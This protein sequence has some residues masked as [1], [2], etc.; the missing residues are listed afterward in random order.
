M[1]FPYIDPVIVQIGP[2]ALRWYGLTYVAGLVALWLLGNYRAQFAHNN[3]TKEQVSDFITY[4]FL[5]IFLGGRF[6][7]V[8]FYNFDRFL[9]NPLYLFKV[10]E[11]GMSF[12]GGL[13]GVCIAFA[14]FARHTQKRYFEVA[15][16]LAP[17][18]PLGLG[19]GRI[20]NFINGE[21]WGREV[22]DQSLPWAMRFACNAEKA[23][24]FTACDP[25]ALLRHPSQLYQALLEGLVLFVI[26]FLFSRKPRPLMSVSGMFLFFYGLFRFIVEFFREPDAHLGLFFG[27]ALS[28]GQIL[29]LPMIIGGGVLVFL[30]Y[31]RNEM[32][33]GEITT[34]QNKAKNDNKLRTARS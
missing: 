10:W 17:M 11:G 21:L 34:K 22:V 29:S 9:D 31:R 18:V 12:H 26:L 1:D 32:P 13:I 28:M 33:R 5:G 14:L 20:G 8:L 19:F 25:A 7:Y 16:F 3:W 23:P 4:A 24:W 15:D 27:N 6:G 30:A 2:L